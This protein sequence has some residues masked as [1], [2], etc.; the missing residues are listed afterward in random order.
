MRIPARLLA[1]PMRRVTRILRGLAAWA[2]AIGLVIGAAPSAHAALIVTMRQEGPDVA[3]SGSGT[4]N[5][6]GLVF[7]ADRAARALIGGALFLGADPSQLVDVDLYDGLT[8]PTTFRSGNIFGIE[9]SSGTGDRFGVFPEFLLIVPDGYVSGAPLNATNVY[10][11][12]TFASLGVTPGNYVWTWGSAAAADSLTLEIGPS[13]VPE[14]V[15]L[16]LLGVGMAG[17]A[18]RRWRRGTV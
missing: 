14:P 17:L 1:A 7:F 10:A 6:T 13:A 16:S 18:V 11:G 2:V 12:A 5:L 8:G 15:S 4:V 9:A 3:V